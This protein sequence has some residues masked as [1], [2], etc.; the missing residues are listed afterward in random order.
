MSDQKTIIDL[1]EHG[2]NSSGNAGF[3]SVLQGFLSRRSVLRGGVGSAATLLLGGALAGCD[4]DD[5]PPADGPPPPPPQNA[6]TLQLNFAAVAHSVA[7]ALVVP[8]G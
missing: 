6:T 5:S 7:D 8:P 1:D 3:D 2:F 4:K